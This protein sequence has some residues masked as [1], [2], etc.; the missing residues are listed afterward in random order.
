M[1]GWVGSPF[2]ARC[3]RVAE[4]FGKARTILWIASLFA[5]PLVAHPAG[6][7]AT[8]DRL[9]A[10]ATN[11]KLIW[12]GVAETPDGRI[13]VE[14]PRIDTSVPNPSIA[15]LGAGGALLPFPGGAWNAW[16]PGADPARAF[17]STNAI[18]LGPDGDL[19]VVD[20]AAAG[21]IGKPPVP[22]GQKIV[23]L[24]PHRGTVVR[25][26]PLGAD[27]LK[28][29]SAI[30]DI[31]FNG[32]RGYITDAG[33]PGL[34]VLDLDTGHARRVLDGDRSTTASR[35]II[36]DG[37]ILREPD[38][39]PAAI[40]A[41]QLEVTPDGAYL[42]FQPLPGPLYRVATKLLDDPA[43]PAAA[44]SKGVEF[45]Y[46]TPSL[47]GTAIDAAGNLYLNDL[48]TD[49]ILKLGPDRHLSLVIRDARL[50]WADAPV[51]DAHGDDV[52]PVPQLDRAA[53]FNHGHSQIR[54]PVVIWRLH[55]GAK[56]PANQ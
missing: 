10:V 29:K 7:A 24:D 16:R 21:F 39:K 52:V 18:H 50:H 11:D 53:V 33:A 36:V 25:V 41:D 40:N 26:Y 23:V 1:F 55:L 49:A 22:G 31:R 20:N 35:P 2:G 28:P 9:T 12:N 17:V 30:D 15:E 47:G 19:W 51:I 54:W 34:I 44:L 45:W 32:R 8:A 5:A 6:A 42:Y 13:F 4:R 27:V 46:D 3:G 37:H 14:F 48:G 38:G 43:V 56:P